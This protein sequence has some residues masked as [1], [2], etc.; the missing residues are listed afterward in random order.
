MI[1]IVGLLGLVVFVVASLVVGGRIL[2]LASRTRQLP[3]TAVSLSL[4]LSG[5]IGTALLVL[6]LLAPDLST[7]AKYVS[8]QAGSVSNH[9]GFA[10]LFLFVWRVFRPREAWA[11][12]L[13]LVSTTVL[14]VGGMG[15]A[16]TLEPGGGVPGRTLAPDL[17][18]WMSLN[19]RFV[20]YGWAAFESFHYYGMLKR[21]LALGLA[22]PVITDRFFYWGVSTAAVFC[23]WVNL[24]VRAVMFN[25]EWIRSIADVVSA[26]LGFIVA[27]S[28]SYAFFPR[29]KRIADL[30]SARAEEAGS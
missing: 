24:A 1:E 8:Y 29:T 7:Y 25:S 4:I 9:I 21:R 26:L 18:F 6:P 5:G 3:E 2:S 15:A 17:W 22:D 30:D 23:I 12:C 11:L 10:L 16:I 20:V 28:L 13:F 19:A 14:L 27:G